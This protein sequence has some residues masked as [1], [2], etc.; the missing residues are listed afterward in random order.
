MFLDEF[1]N[2][3]TDILPDP[4][5]SNHIF[6]GDFNLHIS[7]DHEEIE[8][9]TFIDTIEALALSKHIGFDTHKQGN[10]LDLILSEISNAVQIK[11][12]I[13]GPYLSDHRAVISCLT[14]KKGT[15]R[16][17]KFVSI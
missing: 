7:D 5:L 4:E 15:T 9:A 13:P 16:S 17:T 14:A 8:L 6:L 3:L 12:V 10:I 2:Y 11:L 1:T